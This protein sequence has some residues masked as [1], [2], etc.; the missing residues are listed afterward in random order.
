VATPILIA[1]SMVARDSTGSV[2][3]SAMVY[4]ST[5]VLGAAP[6]AAE[7]PE[8]ALERVPSCT[9]HSRPMTGSYFAITS[10]PADG[11]CASR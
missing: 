10:A 8:N 5:W 11:G 3:G 7:A 6:N 9:W 1:Q 2:P 4:G